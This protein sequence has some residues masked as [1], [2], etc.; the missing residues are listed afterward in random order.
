MDRDKDRPSDQ[1]MVQENDSEK[2]EV[3]GQLFTDKDRKKS[4]KDQHTRG[5]F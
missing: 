4:E 2:T 5:G 3:K 1:R